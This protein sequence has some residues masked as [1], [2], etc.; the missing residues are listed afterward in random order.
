MIQQ[1]VISIQV[2]VVRVLSEE[3]LVVAP[4]VSVRSDSSRG[5]VCLDSSQQKRKHSWEIRCWGTPNLLQVKPLMHNYFLFH[6]LL[7]VKHTHIH[8][9]PPL[10]RHAN[11]SL[12]FKLTYSLR[13][14]ISS[15]SNQVK[16]TCAWKIVK[17]DIL[18]LVPHKFSQPPVTIPFISFRS[19]GRGGN[20]STGSTSRI[21]GETSC[22]KDD[23]IRG[24]QGAV[25]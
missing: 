13:Q 9:Q 17:W 18:W 1:A 7:A 4:L 22:G 10:F 23:T 6:F 12:K 20:V 5:P 24:I 25:G 3:V 11:S 2:A 14:K 15:W 8:R 19:K 16:K 21:K